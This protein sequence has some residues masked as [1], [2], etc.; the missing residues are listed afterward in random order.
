MS[1]VAGVDPGLRHCGIAVVD[2]E[3]GK[4]LKA[5]LSKNPERDD[6]GPDAW[7]SMGRKVVV[8]LA[9]FSDECGDFSLGLLVVERMRIHHGMRNWATMMTLSAIVG[10]IL[11]EAKAGRVVVPYPKE[12]K[13][14]E[15]KEDNNRHTWDALELDER[16]VAPD[17]EKKSTGDNVL[18]AIALAKWGSARYGALVL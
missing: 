14:N 9:S 18:D 8:D 4:L 11:A 6:D 16:S 17:A 7:L 2:A 3:T 10:V 1:L 13:D 5:W 15:S 12:W